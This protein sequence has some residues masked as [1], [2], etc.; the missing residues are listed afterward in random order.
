[1]K[2]IIKLYGER[3][4]S[5]NYLNKLIGLNLDAYRIPGLVPPCIMHLENILPG[6]EYVR[7]LYFRV[8]YRYNLG[9]KHTR[10]KPVAELNK[11]KILAKDPSFVTITKNPYS[12]IL[13]LYRNPYH[14]YYEN[15]PDFETFLHTPWHTVDREN[16]PE[17][18][19]NPM[20]LW[21]IKNSSYLQLIEL[22]GLNITTES[23][24]ANPSAV[25]DTISTRFA[26]AK[27]SE[28]FVDYE[29][30]TKEQIKDINYYRDYYL[31]EKWRKNLSPNAI[32]IINEALDRDLMRHF[33]YAMLSG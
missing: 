4:T 13:S 31:Q 30:S 20:E 10:V 22:G 11:Y 32:N 14:Q 33:G 16:C 3:N 24:F 26:I 7:D 17:T 19:K 15:K 28:K 1:M 27:T 9:W 5:T 21:N 18:L 12:W 29:Q 23:L 6:K 25:I 2:K 8:M